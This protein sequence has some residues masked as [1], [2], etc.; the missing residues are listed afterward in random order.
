MKR[1]HGQC[2]CGKVH[3]QADIDLSA[4]TFR[5]NCTFCSKVRNWT[6][7]I[8]PEQ[9][10]L[11]KG[12]ESLSTYQF[13]DGVMSHRFC[14]HCGVRT[15]TQGCIE[16]LGGSVVGVCLATLDATPEELAAA[17]VRYVDGLQEKWLE[18]PAVVSHL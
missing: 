9:F 5:C 18:P 3:Y 16:A 14:S 15:F 10:Q 7:I 17:P 1:Y 12:E 2:H 8:K 11:L 6:S 4:G 13:A